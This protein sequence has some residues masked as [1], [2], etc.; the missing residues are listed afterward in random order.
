MAKAADQRGDDAQRQQNGSWPG[1]PG[2]DLNTQLTRPHAFMAPVSPEHD[3][4]RPARWVRR[5][6]LSRAEIPIE[7]APPRRHRRDGEFRRRRRA[8]AGS[9]LPR[10]WPFTA[11]RARRA[12]ADRRVASAP[13][14]RRAH[15]QP[16]SRAAERAP[17]RLRRSSADRP[18]APTRARPSRRAEWC[19][20][21]A[22]RQVERRPHAAP[23]RAGRSGRSAAR[24]ATRTRRWREM[25]TDRQNGGRVATAACCRTICAKLTRCPA[26]SD[27][28]GT[29]RA[30]AGSIP[31][32][33]GRA[34]TAP[35][36]A[37][38]GDDRRE[39][40]APAPAAP[41]SW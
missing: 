6:C 31:P 12:P 18:T 20:I 37:A 27:S 28:A 35:A 22:E 23:V 25:R 14:R 32:P 30:A 8:A 15:C 40:P 21:R 38:A 5:H 16:A 26:G 34:P 4:S 36:S 1:A 41:G 3:R 33:R 2:S 39:T 17:P 10:R 29:A 7:A 19:G 11:S 24:S 9:T 13:E